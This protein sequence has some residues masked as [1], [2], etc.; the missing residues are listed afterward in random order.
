M[1]TVTLAAG[2]A[3]ALLA[4]APG[5]SAAPTITFTTPSASGSFTGGFGNMDISPGDFVDTYTFNLPSGVAGFTITSTFNGDVAANNID[6][7]LV[8]F[9]GV[10]FETGST[11]NNEY[12]FLN[13]QHAIAGPQTLEVRGNSGGD[14][15]YMGTLAFSLAAIPEPATWGMMLL[16]FGGLGAVLRTKRPAPATSAA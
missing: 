13:G 5:A 15:T 16:G 10:D 12:R 4:M 7:S 2:L 14:G 11:G 3:A 8:R 9:N 1:K 6:F